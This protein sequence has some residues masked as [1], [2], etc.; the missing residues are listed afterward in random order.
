MLSSRKGTL[1][2]GA[3]F[4]EVGRR[5]GAAT[6]LTGGV[7]AAQRAVHA[8]VERTAGAGGRGGRR[9]QIDGAHQF[10]VDVV[11]HLCQRVVDLQFQRLLLA[12]QQRRRR[13]RRRRRA[14][15]D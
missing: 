9:R 7:M 4:D 14:A 3:V 12:S 10:G 2:E 5:R 15:A 1:T 13:R 11:A 6:E 8:P